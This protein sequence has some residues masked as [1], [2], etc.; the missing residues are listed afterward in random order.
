MRII[1]ILTLLCLIFFPFVKVLGRTADEPGL[2]LFPHWTLDG[3]ETGGDLGASVALDGDFNGDGY[4][5]LV[6]GAPIETY[7]EYREG[8][9]S[10]YYSGSQLLTP[11]WIQGSGQLGARFGESLA[12]VGDVDQDDF[13]DLLIGAPRYKYKDPLGT[14]SQQGAVYLYR[15]AGYGM[16][17]FPNWTYLGDQK[18]AELGSAVGPAG[19]LNNDGYPDVLV[20]AKK[21]SQYYKNEGLVYAFYGQD[22]SSETDPG[23]SATP[24]WVAY[25]GS[26]TANFG[27]SVAAL[28]DVNGDTFADIVVG[29]P[30]WDRDTDI[31]YEDGKVMVFYGTASGLGD[32]PSWTFEGELP[33]AQLGYAVAGPGDINQDGFNDLLVGAP[34][35]GYGTNYLHLGEGKVYLFLGDEYG[36]SSS[37]DWV[38]YG[39]VLNANLGWSLAGIGDLNQDGLPDVAI[40][41]YQYSNDQFEEGRAFVYY[42]TGTGLADI[43]A[44][45]AEG[46]KSEATFG[47]AVSGGDFNRDGFVDLAVGAPDYRVSEDIV[48]RA[49]LF[50]GIPDATA[51]QDLKKTYLPVIIK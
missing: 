43:P 1:K 11:D 50:L 22:T 15:G 31:G 29:A 13:D 45:W 5:D 2:E 44:W 38:A 18:E 25:G 49:Y 42:G 47:Y 21:Y 46:D 41:A 26:A 9:V 7:N 6:I 39:G 27:S 34:T 14:L 3:V 30:G 32:T 40:G 23:L 36:F 48:G 33:Y 4:Q 51:P 35:H 24:N 10:V 17:T 37:P 20:G 28:G 19:D 12:S 8:V 16:F